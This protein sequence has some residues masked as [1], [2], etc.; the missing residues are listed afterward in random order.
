[1]SNHSAHS[2]QQM[3]TYYHLVWK[4][5]TNEERGGRHM[6]A[7]QIQ[8]CVLR[9]DVGKPRNEKHTFLTEFTSFKGSLNPARWLRADFCS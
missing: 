6:H 2:P 1:M 7:C 3:T 5:R 9:N 8:A 4:E